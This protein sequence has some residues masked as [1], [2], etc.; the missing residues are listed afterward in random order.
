MRTLSIVVFSL[1]ALNTFAQKGTVQEK[2]SFDA[3]KE[4]AK[5][6]QPYIESAKT[7]DGKLSRSAFY[8]HAHVV[9]SVDG[10]VYN[11]TADQFEGIVD[12]GGPS[13]NVGHHIAWIDISGPAAA[14]KVE[15]YDWGGFRFTDF[16]VLYKKDGKWK[17]S[18][19]VY[20]SHSRN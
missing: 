5:A 4:V 11:V 18:G 15:F 7:G 9:G 3:Y 1:I 12:E 2:Q 20:D 14:A 19:K 8:A 16:F 13:E 10:E 17:I 6:L